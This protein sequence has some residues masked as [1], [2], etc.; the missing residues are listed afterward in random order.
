MENNHCI[1]GS[2]SF[3]TSKGCSLKR[4]KLHHSVK[5][6]AG[7]IFK[8]G[9]R[10]F[11]NGAVVEDIYDTLKHYEAQ[12]KKEAAAPQL[13]EACKWIGDIVLT[14]NDGGAAWCAVRERPGAE[15]WLDNLRV[16]L[17]VVEGKV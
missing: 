1:C 6:T 14:A 11:E 15:E 7:E 3:N 16:A 13:L 4:A 2:C 12:S 8:L 10:D 5:I 9:K 17:S